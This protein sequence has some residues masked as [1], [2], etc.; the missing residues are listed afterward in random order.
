MISIRN[1]LLANDIIIKGNVLD[2]L[3]NHSV[4]FLGYYIQDNGLPY[5]GSAAPIYKK[6]QDFLDEPRAITLEHCRYFFEANF[7][8]KMVKI[9]IEIWASEKGKSLNFI[10]EGKNYEH[11]IG[12]KEILEFEDF[13]PLITL[14][15]SINE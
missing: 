6:I 13:N 11:I 1:W 2:I 10:I 15:N 7:E 3:T 4:Q 12:E 14:L 9:T 8:K 5:F